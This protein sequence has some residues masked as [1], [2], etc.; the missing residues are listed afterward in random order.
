MVDVSLMQSLLKAV[1]DH[2]A[3][4]IVGDID[5]LPSVGPGQVLAD[6]IGS[7]AVP[8]V[9][10]TEVFR[11]R[12]CRTAPIGSIEQRSIPVWKCE[13]GRLSS[14]KDRHRLAPYS[15]IE[16]NATRK[17]AATCQI[18]GPVSARPADSVGRPALKGLARLG[19]PDTGEPSHVGTVW[20]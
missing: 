2:A 17:D 12:T 19:L 4:L 7:G 6:I 16:H 9:R 20:E 3:L 1:P 13:G 18:S 11:H 10:L 8:T 15:L 5:Q 14:L